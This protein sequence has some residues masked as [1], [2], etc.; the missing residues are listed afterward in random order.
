VS[1]RAFFVVNKVEYHN[2]LRNEIKE[3]NLILF[4]N[5]RAA[6]VYKCGLE[7]LNPKSIYAIMEIVP[8]TYKQV[9]VWTGES[10]KDPY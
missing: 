6:E 2:I 10:D 8:K 5:L 3:E 9:S 4:P 7:T 1:K